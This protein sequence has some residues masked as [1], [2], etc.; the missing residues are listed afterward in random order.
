[1]PGQYAMQPQPERR[2]SSARTQ[3]A[4]PTEQLRADLQRQRLEGISTRLADASELAGRTVAL[5]EEFERNLITKATFFLRERRQVRPEE[6]LELMAH[7]GRGLV[8]A[9]RELLD[10]REVWESLAGGELDPHAV[11]LR[12]K[13]LLLEAVQ[14]DVVALLAHLDYG[15]GPPPAREWAE[16]IQ[17]PLKLLVHGAVPQDAA[18]LAAGAEHHL[19]QLVGRLEKLVDEAQGTSTVRDAAGTSALKSRLRRL[20]AAAR[21]QVTPSRL[22]LATVGSEVAGVAAVS[23]GLDAAVTAGGAA[24]VTAVLHYGVLALM[25][26]VGSPPGARRAADLTTQLETLHDTVALAGN[27]TCTPYVALLIRRAAV[28]LAL[29]AIPALDGGAAE[30]WWDWVDEVESVLAE[31]QVSSSSALALYDRAHELVTKLAASPS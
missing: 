3:S 8:A 7:A 5:D 18:T 19:R 24:G 21:D 9:Y 12:G 27:Q 2:V 31:E 23:G 11:G 1:M 30:R 22:L 13:L 14:Q 15:E 25:A 4:L 20:L 29:D 10:E 28:Q 26:Q 16:R 17:E 6:L